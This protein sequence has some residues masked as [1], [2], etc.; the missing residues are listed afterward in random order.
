MASVDVERLLN[1]QARLFENAHKTPIELKTLG[2]TMKRQGIDT[3]TLYCN[4]KFM[5]LPFAECD[6]LSQLTPEQMSVLTATYFASAYA[7][8]ASSETLALRY[9]M[10]VSEMVFP[11]YS[12]PY[13]IL[14]H[15]TDEE[16]DHIITFRNVCQALVGRGDVIGVKHFQHLKPVYETF[17][18]YKDRLCPNGF[19]GMYLLMR[20]LLN[21]ALKQLEGFMAANIPGGRSNPLAMEIITGHAEDEAR[22]LTTSIELGLGLLE[23]ATPE[24][25]N[26][27]SSVLRIS[28]YSMID[29]RFA[30]DLSNVWHHEA[31]VA[32]L[33]R[34]LKHPAFADFPTTASALKASW[35][36]AGIEIQA[37]AE[38]E[39]SRRWLASQIARL[40]DRLGLKLTPSGESFERYQDYVRPLAAAQLAS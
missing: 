23:R 19:G 35:G 33:D 22:H 3:A 28:L 8:I 26:L 29:K 10:A 37:S 17:E 2:I 24:S 1:I 7:E 20:Y 38:F 4:P 34:A 32:V 12:D 27:V 14:F 18:R 9:N 6:H 30:S 25:R 36:K 31:S 11:I 39:N 13:M 21:L 16:M 5:L 40:V 15:E